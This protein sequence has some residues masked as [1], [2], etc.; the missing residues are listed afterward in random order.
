LDVDSSQLNF[1]ILF[2]LLEEV[3]HAYY[4]LTIRDCYTWLDSFINHSLAFPAA[5]KWIRL[6]DIRFGKRYNTLPKE[7]KA[8]MDLGLYSLEGYL[9][10]WAKHNQKVISLV[11]ENKL[12]I[13]KTDKI[14]ESIQKISDFSGYQLFNVTSD[15]THVFKNPQK[16]NIL[17]KINEEYLEEKVKKYCSIL[18]EQ[19]F[20]EIKSINDV[21]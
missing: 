18:M 1:F 2:F 7:E 11:P 17:R 20:P 15:Q 8:L 4:I 13:I 12:L 19:Y 6:R 14:S 3:E 9:Q 16:F 10:Y 5:E 21:F